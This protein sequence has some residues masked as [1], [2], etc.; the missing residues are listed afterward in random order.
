MSLC[1]FF[2]L[3]ASAVAKRLEPQSELST[4]CQTRP[5]NGLLIPM[6]VPKETTFY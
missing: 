4:P 2:T 5:P 1:I 3:D 6:Y